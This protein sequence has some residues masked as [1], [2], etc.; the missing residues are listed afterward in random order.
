MADVQDEQQKRLTLW[1]ALGDLGWFPLVLMGV[2]GLSIID[3][4]EQAVFQDLTL[5]KLFQI[6]LNGYHRLTSLIG[7][8]VEPLFIPAIDWLNA[9]FSWH[10]HLQKHWRALFFLLMII[11]TAEV[12]S[13]WREGSRGQAILELTVTGLGAVVG[14]AAFGLL[15]PLSL[16]RVPGGLSVIAAHGPVFFAMGVVLAIGALRRG[17]PVRACTLFLTMSASTA[18]IAYLVYDQLV[19]TGARA[20]RPVV[21]DYSAG[22]L[23][24]MGE[25]A[26]MGVT[27]LVLGLR[28]HIP[29]LVRLRYFHL[30]L[31]I[32][33]GFVAA[34]LI[35][36]SNWAVMALS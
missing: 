25:L 7:A 5:I 26:L 31:S 29:D 2:G 35:L 15:P 24:M 21:A 34:A 22:I 28:P 17:H 23:V 16:G 12:R 4:L 11:A 13:K 3:I 36:L 14:S 20:N 33:G 30:G 10:L 19:A 18:L 6:V 9:H 32:L 27:M 1:G 8:I